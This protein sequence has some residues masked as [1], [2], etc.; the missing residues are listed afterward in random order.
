VSDGR[1]WH[2]IAIPLRADHWANL[3]CFFPLTVAEWEQLMRVLAAMRPAVVADDDAE[4][5]KP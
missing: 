3:A 1:Q 2:Q 5:N 4:G